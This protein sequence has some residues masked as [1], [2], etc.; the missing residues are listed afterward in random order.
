MSMDG[1]RCLVESDDSDEADDG[2]GHRKG[3]IEEEQG[4]STAAQAK[5]AAVPTEDSQILDEGVERDAKGVCG[6]I[7]PFDFDDP[8]NMRKQN[9]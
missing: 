5:G 7:M 3:D 6:E 8:G 9:Q 4:K 2:E 1:L